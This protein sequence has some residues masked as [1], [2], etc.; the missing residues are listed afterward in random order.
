MENIVSEI[1][2]DINEAEVAA[3]FATKAGTYQLTIEIE[4]FEDQH[5]EIMDRIKNIV[6]ALID[7]GGDIKGLSFDYQGEEML[8]IEESP[9]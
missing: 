6:S 2:V 8:L 5:G 9:E 7:Q 1:H 3:L 4:S